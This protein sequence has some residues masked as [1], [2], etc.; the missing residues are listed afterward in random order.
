MDAFQG[1]QGDVRQARRQL[2]LRDCCCYATQAC[3]DRHTAALQD[4]GPPSAFGA[5]HSNLYVNNL[6]P[7]VD[8]ATL[9]EAFSGC[10]QVISACVWRDQNTKQRRVTVRAGR[11]R[12]GRPTGCALRACVCG[13]G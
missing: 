12:Q 11:V 4:Y 10:G 6:A 8:D 3:A 9:A 2:A 7:E 1:W 13:R 5:E